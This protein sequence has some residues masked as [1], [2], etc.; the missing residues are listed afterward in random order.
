MNARQR[1]HGFFEQLFDAIPHPYLIF[2][3]DAA[4]H[5]VAV[6]DR[7][8]EVTGLTRDAIVG[9]A[10]HQLFSDH[11]HDP[12]ASD[13]I[14]LRTSLRRVVDERRADLMG[15]RR[16]G[17]ALRDGSGVLGVGYRRLVNTPLFTGDGS[18]SFIIHQ[19]EEVDESRFE[20][21]FNQAAVGLALVSPEGRWLRVNRKLCEIVG[22]SEEELL[23]R[24]FLDITHAEDRVADRDA[25][26]RMNARE[27][28]CF[29]EDKRYI[30]RDGAPVWIN[31]TV[32]S[33]LK[34]D[35]GV[36]YFITVVQDIQA[37]KLAEEALRGS[38]ERLQLFIEHAPAALAMFDRDMRYL[39]VSRRWIADYALAGREIIGHSHYEVF[40]G[41]PEHWKAVHR[42]CLAGEVL[43][44]DEERFERFDGSVRWLRWDVRPWHTSRGGIGGIMI[45]TEDITDRKTTELAL[46]EREAQYRAVIETAADGFW[47]LDRTGHI[48]AVNDAYARRSGYTH[49]ELHD[50]WIGDID[51]QES[52]EEAKQHIAKVIHKGDD[53]FE[54]THRT[55][56]G[57][58]WPVEINASYSDIAGGIFFAF[59]RDITERKL[60]ERALRES[61]DRYR[62]LFAH[63][64]DAI[65]VSQRNRVT[66][67]NQACLKLFDVRTADTL[68]G[69][70][71]SDLFQA[72]FQVVM[73]ERLHHMREPGSAALP[74]EAKIVR[75][76]GGTID[77]DVLAAPF[78]IGGEEATHVIL[79]DISE[80]KI[81]ERQIIEASSAEQERIGHEIHDGIGQQLTAL[82]MLANSLERKL[83]QAQRPYEARLAGNL[84]TYLQQTVSEVRLLSKGLS[85]IEIGPEGLVDALS[86]LVEHVK[87]SSG[88]GCSLVV[89]GRI[90]HLAEQ[91]AMHLF[92]ITQ[93]ALNNAVKHA[94]ATHIEVMLLS[95]TSRVELSVRDDGV[96]I[97]PKEA[98]GDRLGLKIMHYRAVIIGAALEVKSLPAGGSLV[99][100]TL[101]MGS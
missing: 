39:A 92:R 91:V 96:G 33:A 38:E 16:Y 98:T 48:I 3:A 22:Y 51:A 65:L 27:I 77:V 26:R 24:N 42:R 53:L 23:A 71:T 100:C 90:G 54:T 61:E 84:V 70:T 9:R 12:A 58:V 1:S 4:F 72:D 20:T 44:E 68:V 81:L 86:L 67:V 87:A 97:G 11:R 88:L 63:S 19:L 17:V 94:Q 49:E 41:I 52:P 13:L 89:K 32:V 6:N 78:T 69:S 73:R 46:A 37:R 5:I 47:M 2:K 40:P 8:L 56:D 10:L 75:A 36:D 101:P 64:P 50:M 18:V 57:E 30:R 35:G 83:I 31:L 59:S 14:A 80:R 7:Y 93:E 99:R 79:R 21:L 28:D 45:F 85:P 60:A 82:G 62:N 34:P 76:G 74:I 43:H 25:L 15:V 55:K 29:T 66:L 95:K